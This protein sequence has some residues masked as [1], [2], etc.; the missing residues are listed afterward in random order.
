MKLTK[1]KLQEIIKEELE[2]LVEIK[3][4][5]PDAKNAERDIYYWLRL[6]DEKPEMWKRTMNKQK[7]REVINKAL[8]SW[9]PRGGAS[10][11]QGPGGLGPALQK[12]TNAIGPLWDDDLR[13]DL[14]DA[15]KDFRE[16][17][18]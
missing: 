10:R 13:R 11:E 15:Y 4:Q 17:Y 8:T 9:P 12:F 3:E 5:H 14:G 16:R 7:A 1:S 2:N 18:G 6:K